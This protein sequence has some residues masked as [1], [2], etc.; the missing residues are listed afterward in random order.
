VLRRRKRRRKVRSVEAVETDVRVEM[1][2]RV[3]V[4]LVLDSC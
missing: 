1:E 2:A 4:A 3:K